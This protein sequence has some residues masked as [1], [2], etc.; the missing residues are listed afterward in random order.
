MDSRYLQSDSESLQELQ[1]AFEQ[2]NHLS[3]SLCSSVDDLNQT[4]LHLTQPVIP[5]DSGVKKSGN[6]QLAFRLR[7]LIDAIPGSV[8]ANRRSL[9]LRLSASRT[10][11]GVHGGLFPREKRRK[12]GHGTS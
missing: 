2:F 1:L 9:E 3:A 6:R 4:A 8:V 7:A 10:D 11:T 12:H 5:G